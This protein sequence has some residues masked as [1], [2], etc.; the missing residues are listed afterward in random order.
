VLNGLDQIEAWG[1]AA[2]RGTPSPC[3]LHIDTGMNR[4][5]LR[6]EEARALADGPERLRRFDVK[7]V[8]SHLACGATPTHPMNPV[9]RR[10][11]MAAA[12]AFPGV[13]R[14]LAASGGA[15]LGPDYTFDMIRPGIS[16]YGGGPFDAPDPRIAPVAT[17]DAPLLQVRTVRPGE[18]IGYG[19]TFTVEKPTRIGI[20]ALGYADGVLRSASGSGYGWLSGRRCDLVGRISMDLIAIN[21]SDVEDAAPGQRVELF[22]AHLPLDLAAAQ[23]GTIAYELLSRVSPRVQRVYRGRVA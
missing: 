10:A 21:V 18:S 3:A 4:L 7:L 1:G 9:Q 14:S 13:P 11:F 2:I 15:F 20:I 12:E 8:M 6:P 5:G 19:A 16:L 23:A 17:L 22:G